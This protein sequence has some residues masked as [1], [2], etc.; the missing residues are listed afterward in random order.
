MKLFRNDAA[1]E[2]YMNAYNEVLATWDIPYE[3]QFIET[4]FGQTYALITGPKD[5]PPLFLLHGLGSSSIIWSANIDVLSRHYRVYALDIIADFGRSI[6]TR[7]P[8]KRTHYTDW[9]LG[10]LD[11]LNI[12]QAHFMGVSFGGWVSINMARE[13]PE[14]VSRIVLLA[15]AATFLR[16]SMPFLLGGAPMWVNPSLKYANRF[17]RWSAANHE[18]EAYQQ[19]MEA[20]I[21]QFYLGWKHSTLRPRVVPGVFSDRVLKRIHTPTLFMIGDKDKIY[22]PQK[23]VQRAEQLLP[24]VT[25]KIVPNA[26]HDITIA[27]RHTIATE[28][29]DFLGH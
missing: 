23:A 6:P 24:H 15:P 16:V 14:R 20:L 19:Y 1:K 10:V 26:S 8:W 9:L 7:S 3:E 28:V 17:M 25:T 18:D 21:Q 2:A 5:A 22:D 12:E 29:P 27:G 4:D 13:H 11:A